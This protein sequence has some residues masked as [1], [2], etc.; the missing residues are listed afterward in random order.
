MR[1]FTTVAVLAAAGLLAA[2]CGGSTS[3]SPPSSSGSSGPHGVLTID[4]ESG[5]TWA[6]DFNPFNLSYI[7]YSLG[8]VYEPL[9]FINALHSGQATPWLATSWAWGN[10]NKTLTFTI[11]NGVK[12]SNGDPLTP[13][14]VA[15]TFNLL[16]AHKT[17]DIN[18][19]WS[20]LNSV[21]T[22]GSNQVVMQF[23]TVAVPY[24]Y[25]IADQVAIVDQK[26][27]SK[28][29]NPVTYPDKNPIG[30]GAYTVSSSTCTPQNIKY[31][32]NKNYWQAGLPKVGTVNYPSFLTN[33]TANT[34]LANGQA[35][36]GSQFI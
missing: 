9:V 26:V 17:L 2:A 30:T 11:R 8:N 36:W 6:C 1:R 16:K 29:A 33:D 22:S 34:Y 12:F 15:Y 13:A 14:D 7:S 4:N 27:W 18:S 21:A 3:S 32:A 28:V 5:G 10:G 24:F 23:K 31:T 19:V 25:Y 35:Q 20:V